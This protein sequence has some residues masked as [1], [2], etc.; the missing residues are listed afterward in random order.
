[1]IT[2]LTNWQGDVAAWNARN[3]GDEKSRIEDALVVCEEAGE[4]ARAVLKQHQ[5]IRGT[6]AEWQDEIAKEIGDVVITLASLAENAGLD[7]GDCIAARWETVSARD[8][9]TDKIGHGLPADGAA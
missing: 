1:M 2:N 6:Y 8:F 7:L 4:L 9:T 5:G 3:F